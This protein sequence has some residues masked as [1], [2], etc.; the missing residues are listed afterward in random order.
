MQFHGNNLY[1]AATLILPQP[2]QLIIRHYVIL[3]TESIVEY[4]RDVFLQNNGSLSTN[5]AALYPR[6]QNSS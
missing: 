4:G 6:K 5:Y 2:L 3:V 1:Q